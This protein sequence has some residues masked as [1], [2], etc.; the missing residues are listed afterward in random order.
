MAEIKAHQP[1]Y[2]SFGI[3]IALFDISLGAFPPA[4]WL[5]MRLPRSP[6]SQTEE[7]S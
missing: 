6:K 1:I 5:Q 4:H 7:K 3:N 2:T